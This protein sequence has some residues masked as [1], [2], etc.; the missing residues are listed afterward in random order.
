[1]CSHLPPRDLLTVCRTSKVF[2]SFL[3][4]RQ[5]RAIWIASRAQAGFP[6]L[7]HIQLSPLQYALN[8]FGNGLCEVSSSLSAG[9]DGQAAH[10]GVSLCS[11]QICNRSRAGPIYA[12]MIRQCKECRKDLLVTKGNNLKRELPDLH[13]RALEC[14]LHP[15]SES[16]GFAARRLS[17]EAR[18][19]LNS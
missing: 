16:C 5:S 15:E 12:L 14:T 10:F 9:L 13:P 4:S 19:F 7:Q 1:V 3:L 11:A 2:R 6:T 8:L 17:R 18:Y